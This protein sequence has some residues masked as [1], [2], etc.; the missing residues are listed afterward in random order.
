MDARDKYLVWKETEDLFTALDSGLTLATWK[1]TTGKP[2]PSLGASLEK[3]SGLK[4]YEPFKSKPSDQAYLRNYFG[5]HQLL[6]KTKKKETHVDDEI[7]NAGTYKD[8]KD[9][10]KKVKV[11]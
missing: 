7:I 4:D 3:S 11:G 10:D 9:D 1:K 5:N 8:Y 2:V 6:V